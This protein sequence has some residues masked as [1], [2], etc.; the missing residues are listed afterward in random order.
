MGGRVVVCLRFPFYDVFF[1][2]LGCLAK[3][4]STTEI[5]VENRIDLS[6]ALLTK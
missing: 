6:L 4:R 5:E 1:C 2:V 3:V